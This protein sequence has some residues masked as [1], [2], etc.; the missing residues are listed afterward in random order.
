MFKAVDFF[1]LSLKEIGVE[2]LIVLHI[3]S[4]NFTPS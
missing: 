1:G 4:Q 3:N 2:R